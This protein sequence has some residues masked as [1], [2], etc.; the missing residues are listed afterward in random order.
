MTS[1]NNVSFTLN[2]LDGVIV[3]NTTQYVLVSSTTGGGGA[4]GS[5]FSGI[6]VD[7]NSV[8]S[9]ITLTINSAQPV[10]YYANS[11]L[12][13][14]SNGPG[15]GYNIDVEVVPEPSTYALLLGGLALLVVFQRA[16]RRNNG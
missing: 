3:P 13:L 16:R 7:A 12:K 1:F 10:G 11:Y 8:I 6:S 14:V 2:I 5:L 9:G 15:A 4:G